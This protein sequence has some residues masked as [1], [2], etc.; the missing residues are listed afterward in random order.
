[1]LPFPMVFLD[2]PMDIL[3]IH[4]IISM[5][6]ILDIHPI[7]TSMDKRHHRCMCRNSNNPTCRRHN[8]YQLTSTTSQRK[9]LGLITLKTPRMPRTNQ[10]RRLQR[11]RQRRQQRQVRPKRARKRN[12]CR[13]RNRSRHPRRKKWMIPIMLISKN[14]NNEKQVNARCNIHSPTLARQ[15]SDEKSSTVYYLF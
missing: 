13:H 1:M 4:P 10:C 2:P 5:Q 7:I 11:R 9:P 8:P 6:D 14:N 3:D 12:Q 15:D